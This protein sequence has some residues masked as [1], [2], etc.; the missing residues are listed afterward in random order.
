MGSSLTTRPDSSSSLPSNAMGFRNPSNADP[1]VD[2]KSQTVY[3]THEPVATRGG[4][5]KTSISV[6][7]NT[8][9][10][11]ITL[12]FGGVAFPK[13]EIKVKTVVGSVVWRTENLRIWSSPSVEV[14]IPTAVFRNSDYVLELIGKAKKGTSEVI[15]EYFLHVVREPGR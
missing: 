10:A 13:Y 5:R 11:F 7:P 3:I 2:N 12:I 6:N 15:N 4:N 9:I 14:L 8:R 1:G